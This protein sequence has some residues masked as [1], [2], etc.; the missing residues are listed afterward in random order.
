VAGDEK[1]APVAK[2]YSVVYRTRAPSEPRPRPTEPLER[3]SIVGREGNDDIVT[4]QLGDHTCMLARSDDRVRVQLP[5]VDIILTRRQAQLLAMA[6]LGEDAVLLRLPMPGAAD[7]STADSMTVR[8]RRLTERN[9][10]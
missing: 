1:P 2:R 7:P 6:L 9:W 8:P 3:R 5:N 4:L 10:R